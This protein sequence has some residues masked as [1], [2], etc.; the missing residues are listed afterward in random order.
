MTNL[1]F[2]IPVLLLCTI[3]YSIYGDKKNNI[4]CSNIMNTT[5]IINTSDIICS[6]NITN[7]TNADLKYKIITNDTLNNTKHIRINEL[8]EIEIYENELNENEDENELNYP[9][10]VNYPI[11]NLYL[12]RM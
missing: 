2:Y 9:I 7:A 1:L 3:F 12:R 5:N 11:A 6:T 10:A 4:F 8:Y